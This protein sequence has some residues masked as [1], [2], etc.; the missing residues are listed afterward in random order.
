M[1]ENQEVQEGMLLSILAYLDVLVFVP[2]IIGR[3]NP[4]VRFHSNQGLK[5]LVVSIITSLFS[6]VF[7]GFFARLL[8]KLVGLAV[9]VLSIIGIINVINRETKELP[10]V[11]MIPNILKD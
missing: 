1:N 7:K 2:L 10:L 6:M 5:L 8:V 11:N 9:I 4:T 3:N